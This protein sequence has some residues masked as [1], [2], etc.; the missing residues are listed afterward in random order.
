M[1]AEANGWNVQVGESENTAITEG[2][3]VWEGMRLQG[4]EIHTPVHRFKGKAEEGGH[5]GRGTQMTGEVKRA[6][7]QPGTHST[8]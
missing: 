1:S 2:R 4:C 6:I 5:S 8:D 3:R 7:K